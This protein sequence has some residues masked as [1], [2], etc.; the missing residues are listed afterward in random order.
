MA[1]AAVDGANLSAKLNISG[2]FCV[3]RSKAH[4]EVIRM[5]RLVCLILALALLACCAQAEVDAAAR[6]R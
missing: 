3:Y 5:R 6:E 4:M 2:D 1:F